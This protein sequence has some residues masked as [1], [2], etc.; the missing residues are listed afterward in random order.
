MT[1]IGKGGRDCLGKLIGNKN[2]KYHLHTNVKYYI[3]SRDGLLAE[4]EGIWRES[5]KEG[6]D[7]REGREG[8]EA[9]VGEISDDDGEAS[10]RTGGTCNKEGKREDVLDEG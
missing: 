8:I 7:G 2:I 4:T 10:A 5:A 9:V 1:D 6:E 3:Y